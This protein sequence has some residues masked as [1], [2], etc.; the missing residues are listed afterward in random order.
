M[1][2]TERAMHHRHHARDQSYLS[3]YHVL[4]KLYKVM[5]TQ[6]DFELSLK[7]QLEAF[8]RFPFAHPASS[9]SSGRHC[10]TCARLG[11]VTPN[12]GHR[13]EAVRIRPVRIQPPSTYCYVE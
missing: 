10:R 3:V 2:R 11:E 6:L 4:Y 12:I 8:E 1:L 7:Y 5:K 9:F 13:R